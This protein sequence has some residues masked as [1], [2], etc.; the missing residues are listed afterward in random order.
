V[1]LLVLPEAVG[2]PVQQLV[3][4]WWPALHFVVTPP[5]PLPLLVI[6][7]AAPGEET[8]ASYFR[9]RMEVIRNTRAL[10]CLGLLVL[11][12]WDLRGLLLGRQCSHGSN[13]QRE[14]R[15][16]CLAG[17][18]LGIFCT[19]S[20]SGLTGRCRCFARLRIG[21]F[22]PAGSRMSHVSPPTGT[23]TGPFF[24]GEG[25]VLLSYLAS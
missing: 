13:A 14:P 18:S 25:L 15:L 10:H 24:G 19:F 1:G 16:A 7:F 5:P 4:S 11:R 17:S 23:K 3:R 20:T 6:L 8:E 9:G 12:F 21:L 22:V 2:Y